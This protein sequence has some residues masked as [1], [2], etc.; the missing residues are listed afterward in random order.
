MS[1]AGP[2]PSCSGHGGRQLAGPALRG[3]GRPQHALRPLCLRTRAYSCTRGRRRR[4]R[5]RLLLSSPP[6]ARLLGSACLAWCRQTPCVLRRPTPPAYYARRKP[7]AL[8][9]WRQPTLADLCLQGR[10][11]DHCLLCKHLHVR[12]LGMARQKVSH[13]VANATSSSEAGSSASQAGC[14]TIGRGST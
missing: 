7:A 2:S 4:S 1:P 9:S 5:W 8:F 12:T 14:C 3:R 11:P 6:R 10:H 13:T